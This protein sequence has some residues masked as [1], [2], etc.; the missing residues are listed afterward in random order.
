MVGVVFHGGSSSD[1]RRQQGAGGIMANSV[2]SQHAARGDER[3]FLYAS[4]AM[5]AVI[6]AGFSLQLIAGRSSFSAPL[7][8]H[9]HAI[10]FMGWVVLYVLQN[11]F[12]AAGNLALHRRLG[13]IGA[14]WIIAMIVLGCAVTIAIVRR[15]QT[16]FFFVPQHFLVFDPLSLFTFAGLTVTAIVMRRHTDWH[17]RLHFC[18]MAT[19]LGPAI[20][21][22]LPMP[23]LIPWAWEATLPFVLLFPFVAAIADVRRNGQVHPAFVRGIAVIAA[24]MLMTEAV[25]YSPV[26]AAL[27]R[28][29][30]AGSPGAGVA[31][32]EFPPPPS[33]PLITGQ[34]ASM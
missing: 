25:A 28:A 31:P 16:P 22:L 21:R 4:F 24:S 13:W 2:R 33:G 14:V 20:G 6:V 7:L 32:L 3:F 11:R 23:L 26:G 1:T 5:A 9:A 12:V 15:G 29:V 8:V 30:T 27:Y 18:A 34:T 17:R 19:L 10:V